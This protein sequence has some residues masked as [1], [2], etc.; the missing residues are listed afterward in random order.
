[1]STYIITSVLMSCSY[2]PSPKIKK[3]KIIYIA[4][5]WIHIMWDTAWG[6]E[7]LKNFE[8]DAKAHIA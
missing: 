5:K 6:R 3:V 7:K 2:Q 8:S 1:M 4:I